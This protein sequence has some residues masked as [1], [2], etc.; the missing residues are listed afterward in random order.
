MVFVLAF[1]IRRGLASDTKNLAAQVREIGLEHEIEMKRS[2]IEDR[3]TIDLD[4]K[5]HAKFDGATPEV[6]YL[7][8]KKLWTNSVGMR[9][10]NFG[11]RISDCH[12]AATSKTH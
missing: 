5:C 4:V 2:T 10:R 6:Q 3:R 8:G 9:S 1:S 12:G 11:C 7:S